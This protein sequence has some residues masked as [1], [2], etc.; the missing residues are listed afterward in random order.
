ME[1]N[2]KQCIPQYKHVSFDLIEQFFTYYESVEEELLVRWPVEEIGAMIERVNLQQ[3]TISA[4]MR[5]KATVRRRGGGE[6][7]RVTSLLRT[8]SARLTA[9]AT[10]F[11]RMRRT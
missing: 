11:W 8:R 9:W 3:Q 10:G 7:R 1:R 5:A 4:S 2:I 6:E